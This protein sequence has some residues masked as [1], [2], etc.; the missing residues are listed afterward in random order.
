M[1]AYE[2]YTFIDEH[3]TCPIASH[4]KVFIANLLEICIREFYENIY[5]VDTRKRYAQGISNVLQEEDDENMSLEEEVCE[6]DDKSLSLGMP[7]QPQEEDNEE[8]EDD[9][10]DEQ[11]ETEERKHPPSPPMDEGNTQDFANDK[12]CFYD[13]DDEEEYQPMPNENIIN[14][15]E[16]YGLDMLYDNALH[17]DPLCSLT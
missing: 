7:I 6:E 15:D 11:L 4:Y 1:G 5:V 13:F 16:E 10:D 8:Q 17:D 3:E 9:E 2:L 12:L 14:N